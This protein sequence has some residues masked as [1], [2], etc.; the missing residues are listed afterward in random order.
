MKIP[1]VNEESHCHGPCRNGALQCPTPEACERPDD[2]LPYTAA[3]IIVA[4]VCI[5]AALAMLSLYILEPLK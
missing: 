1:P 4:V 3:D 2:E 5:G